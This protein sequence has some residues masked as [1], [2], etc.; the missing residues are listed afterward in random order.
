[1][2]AVLNGIKAS[3]AL[4]AIVTLG[5]C[6]TG[7]TPEA[8]SVAMPATKAKAMPQPLRGQVVVKQVVGGSET[9]PILKSN[10][11]SSAFQSA[12]DASLRSAGLAAAEGQSGRYELA[13]T[14]QDV[15]QPVFGFEMTVTARVHYEL[16][17]RTTHKSAWEKTITQPFT[18]TM[19]DAF[20]G[21]ERLRL[22]NEGAARLNIENFLDELA[23]SGPGR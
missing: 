9:N 20:Y 8:M 12:L 23:R 3:L 1:M 15:N 22:A 14:I 10:I 4:A 2:S 19:S 17:E 13:V 16:I 7:A 21:P 6:A 11:S 18:A 5:A